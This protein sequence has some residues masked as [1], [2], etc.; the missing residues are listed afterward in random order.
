MSNPFSAI[1]KVPSRPSTARPTDRD[2]QADHQALEQ[3]VSALQALLGDGDPRR[4]RAVEFFSGITL[5]AAGTILKHGL[6]RVP[7][8]YIVT[9]IDSG[10]IVIG[11]RDRWTVD[12]VVLASSAATPV[13][14]FF[15]F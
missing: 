10:R 7:R 8:G 5:V 3:C 15:L 6:G 12:Q 13:V 14:D 4:G 1:L 2:R 11:L 9:F